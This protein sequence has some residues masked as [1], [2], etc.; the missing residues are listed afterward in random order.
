MNLCYILTQ[1][2]S[3]Y[4][5]NPDDLSRLFTAAVGLKM[6]PAKLMKIGERLR[7]VEKA[8]NVREGMTRK[9]DAPPERF[10]EP[11]KSGPG[12]GDRLDRKKLA[13]TMD[14]Y[15]QLRGWDVET[16]LP[17]KAKLVQLG[18][19]EVADDLAKLGKLA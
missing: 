4:L 2:S 17:K 16:G 8:F 7:N 19:K 11:I 12:K 15:Y 1:W 13:K 5:I 18:L 3:P 6:T 9:D 10:F 14:E